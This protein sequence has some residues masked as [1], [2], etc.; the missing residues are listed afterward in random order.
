MGFARRAMC[1]RELVTID[2]ATGNTK[3]VGNLGMHITS[4]AFAAVLPTRIQS[5]TPSGND[6]TLTWTGG[7]PP[8][9]VQ[10]RSS[11]TSG[12][13]ANVGASTSQLTTTIVNGV[14]GS[15]R[16]FRVAGQ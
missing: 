4:L 15:A 5:I 16:Y 9:Q 8:Y 10:A 13:W 2:L 11:L 3:L 7:S 1:S 6:I 14:S 12:N